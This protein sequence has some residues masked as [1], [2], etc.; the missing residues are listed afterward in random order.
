MSKYYTTWEYL[1][2]FLWFVI[3]PFFFSFS[4]R[5]FY[6]WRNTVLRLMGAKIGKGVKIYPSAQ[7]MY[8]W[9]LEIGDYTTISWEVKVYNLAFSKIGSNTMISQYSHLCGGTH[10]YKSKNFDLIRTGF[11]IGNHVWIAAD[12]FI[13]PGVVVHDHA[14]VA[15]RAVV[16]R[17]VE[18]RSI[19]GGNPAKAIGRNE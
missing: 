19:V 8:P 3:E 18:A 5:L 9:L 12:A 15:A 14:V 17:N 6:G 11:T 10:D 1:I 16:I 4:P 2:R 7:I 13:G